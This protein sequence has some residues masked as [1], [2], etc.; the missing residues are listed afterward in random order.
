[1]RLNGVADYGRQAYNQPVLPTADVCMK[2]LATVIG[3]F[4]EQ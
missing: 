2:L 3:R 1:V 4:M